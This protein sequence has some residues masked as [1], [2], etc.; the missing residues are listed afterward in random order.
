MEEDLHWKSAIAY[1]RAGSIVVRGYALTD[2]IGRISFTEMV[3]LVVTG[4]LPSKQVARVMDALLVSAA[5]SGARAPA[6]LAARTVAS[7]GGAITSAVASG[8]LTISAYHGGAV[9]DCMRQLKSI[10]DEVA[11]NSVPLDEA[12]RA[13]VCRR[14]DRGERLGGFGHRMHKEQDPRPGRLF[15]VAREAGLE[16]KYVELVCA[17]E[18]ALEKEKGTRLPANVDAAYAA[19]LCEIDFPSGLANA[20]FLLSRSVGM[21]AHAHEE[22]TRMRPRRHIHPTDWEYD[23]SPPREFRTED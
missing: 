22:R 15:Q 14:L 6:V 17:I 5:E 4:E 12:C 10:Q 21:M 23:G 18:R 9:E 2:L 19:I 8:A 13:A 1:A 16:G 11:S 3:Y 20:L 7:C